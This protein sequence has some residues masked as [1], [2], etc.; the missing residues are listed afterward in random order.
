[1]NIFCNNITIKISLIILVASL[2]ACR[3]A[4]PIP[5]EGDV[6]IWKQSPELI[7]KA[8]LGQRREHVISDPRI[9]HRV[10]EPEYERFIGQFPI[11]Y[12]PVPFP[13]FTEQ[14][15][16]AFEAEYSSKV[17]AVKSAHPIQFHL[18]LN[19][20]KAEATDASP[21]GGSGMD[22]PNQ[23]K[24]FLHGHGTRP[25]ITKSGVKRASYNTKQ[26][27]ERELMKQ[28]NAYSKETKDG[29]ECYRFIDRRGGKRC[30]GHSTHPDISGFEFYVSPYYYS[31]GI[32]NNILVTSQ[33]FAY[34]GIEIIWFTDQKNIYRARDI[35][36]AIWRLLEAWNISPVTTLTQTN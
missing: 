25:I 3:Q 9:E 10:Y 22:N 4:P 23:V 1:M 17:H 12:E 8:K 33:E 18:M 11:D 36:A 26:N 35:D 20:V 2:S 28:L 6:V 14:E 34:G 5:K 15:Y 7:I 19:G 31:P 32:K 21:Y 16:I 30:F 27:F 24:V 13:K 29:L